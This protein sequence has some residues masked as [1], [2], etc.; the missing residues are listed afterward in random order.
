MALATATPDGR[1]SLRMVLLKSVDERGFVFYTNLDSRKGR[2]LK[3]TPLAA[4]C[5]WMAT[6]LARAV[7]VGG[8]LWKDRAWAWG[9]IGK[10]QFMDEELP[11]LTSEGGKWV[12]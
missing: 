8:P 10:T 3:A 7:E 1:P 2:E 5:F 4:L 6:N 9:A 12:N 11:I